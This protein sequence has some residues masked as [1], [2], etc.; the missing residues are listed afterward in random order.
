LTLAY[1]PWLTLLEQLY[2]RLDSAEVEQLPT[3]WLNALARLLPHLT[4]QH[5]TTG[6]G[7]QHQLLA[8]VHALLK[9]AGRPLALFLDD[10]QW[11][12]AASLQLAHFLVERQTPFLLVNGHFP[13][14]L[15]FR[16]CSYT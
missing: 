3:P 14:L 8:A 10:W 6:P 13:P 2:S 12:D 7:Q 16:K 4:K 11:A 5:A 9:L 15:A 1:H